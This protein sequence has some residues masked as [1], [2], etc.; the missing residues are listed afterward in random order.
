MDGRSDEWRRMST[1]VSYHLIALVSNDW[2]GRRRQHR[3]LTSIVIQDDADS[4]QFDDKQMT[5]LGE[6]GVWE[7]PLAPYLTTP[8]STFLFYIHNDK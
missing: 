8:L 5:C 3:R 2:I 1:K 7:A 4:D 6:G